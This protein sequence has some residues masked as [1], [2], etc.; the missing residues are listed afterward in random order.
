MDTQ[1]I[2]KSEIERCAVTMLSKSYGALYDAEV[3]G[4]VESIM[5]NPDYAEYCP[6]GKHPNVTHKW[7]YTGPNF[8]EIEQQI[9]VAKAIYFRMMHEAIINL[10]NNIV[11]YR[12]D[13]RP[14]GDTISNIENV[15]IIVSSL[16]AQVVEF[17]MAVQDAWAMRITEMEMEK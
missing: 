10:G 13:N 14:T 17:H 8:D 7:Q 11:S 1:I 3:T 16:A 4:W 12:I 15:A 5:A 2:V 9:G 6:D